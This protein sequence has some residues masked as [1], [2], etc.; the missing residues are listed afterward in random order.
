MP[1]LENGNNLSVAP[2][3]GQHTKQIM[4]EHGYEINLIDQLIEEDVIFNS[5]DK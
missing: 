2:S 5:F 1:K 4:L 3:L